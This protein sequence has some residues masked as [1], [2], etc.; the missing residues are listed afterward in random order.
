MS[1]NF[2]QSALLREIYWAGRRIGARFT[3][4]TGPKVF[5][6]S[7]PKA[8]T[9][10]ATLELEKLGVRTSG[11][12]VK[13]REVNLEARNNEP[14]LEFRADLATFDRFARKMRPGQYLTGHTPWDPALL[15]YLEANGLRSIIMVRDPRALLVSEHHYIMGLKRHYLHDQLASLP[16]EVSRLRLLLHGSK[17]PFVRG[18][19]RKLERFLPWVQHPDVLTICFENLVGQSGGG[20]IDA[21]LA[22]LKEISGFL[23]V[24]HDELDE[25]AEAPT[26]RT[27]TFRKGR[28]DGWR[29]ELPQCILDE[30]DREIGDLYTE[31]GYGRR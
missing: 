28:V 7:I 20:S 13:T 8:G 24:G 10:L 1:G 30:L 23:P 29:D 26:R 19:R 17:D 14:K 6:N 22:T 2:V 25:L 5:L 31:F 18:I 15:D 9:H 11:I 21:R 27:A 12:H 16:D 4:G 3:G